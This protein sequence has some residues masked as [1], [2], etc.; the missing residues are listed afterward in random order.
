MK[1][2]RELFLCVIAILWVEVRANC[3]SLE[4]SALENAVE[5]GSVFYIDLHCTKYTCQNGQYS[6]ATCSLPQCKD[7]VMPIMDHTK[8]YPDCC[9][10]CPEISKNNSADRLHK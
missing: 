5:E 1:F 10:V 8:R 3:S 7:N 6:R 4:N 9:P 2:Y